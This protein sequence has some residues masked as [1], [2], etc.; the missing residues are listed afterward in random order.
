[1]NASSSTST[2]PAP[3]HLQA[4]E[5][6][7]EIRLARA[8]VKRRVATGDLP[9]A[10]V[11][12]TCPPEVEGMPVSD[13][14]MSQHRWGRTR[15]RKLLAAVPLSETKRLGSMTERQKRAL[16]ELLSDG[17]APVAVC[18]TPP[19]APRPA[20]RELSLVGA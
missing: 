17:A 8:A 4:L 3:Q 6:A 20:A 16:A 7:N 13:L 14:L 18:P 11:V 1:M 9:A 15:C 10:Q 2:T 5:R 19:P 12:L